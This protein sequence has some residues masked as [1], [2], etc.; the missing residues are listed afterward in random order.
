VSF[1]SID[2][3]TEFFTNLMI[4]FMNDYIHVMFII[5]IIII[6]H[7]GQL[8]GAGG[9]GLTCIMEKSAC[10]ISISQ[11]GIFVPGTETDRRVE[12]QGPS[13]NILLAQALVRRRIREVNAERES[14][15]KQT[16]AVKVAAA[17]AAAAAGRGG[18]GGG[19]A[20]KGSAP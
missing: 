17:A 12:F 15:A 1:F 7:R 19:S 3:I 13:A 20:A 18:S 5:I 14:R 4:F 2:N 6:I 11:R 9:V 16:S 10:K 8:V